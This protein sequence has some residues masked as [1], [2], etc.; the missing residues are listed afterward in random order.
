MR[1]IFVLVI[2]FIAVFSF[3]KRGTILV[4]MAANALA[5]GDKA[6]AERLYRKA[7]KME[8]MNFDATL[9]CGYFFIKNG[10]IEDARVILNKASMGGK[11]D[12]LKKQR[13]KS[14]NSLIMWK[15]GQL[16][17]AIEALEEI[18]G[19]GYKTSVVY[20]TLGLYY[21]IKKDKEKALKLCLEA[22]EYN[23]DDDVIVDNLAEAYALCGETEKATELYEELID[24]DPAFPE[25]YYGYGLLLMENGQY[26][27]GI[28]Y[29]GESLEK[30][31]SFLSTL[32]R[33]RVEEIYDTHKKILE[34]DKKEDK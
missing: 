7:A 1:I 22:Y 13:L 17:E 30:N 24:R 9:N 21:I 11:L 27:E 20:E 3:L 10:Y 8:K 15:D 34:E 16:D 23:S 18:M 29:I 4:G 12:K 28:E 5:K 26:E 19:E 2:L 33:E 31:F 25:P 14:I 32:S 6:K